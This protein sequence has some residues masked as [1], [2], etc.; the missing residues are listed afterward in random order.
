M[1]K[2]VRAWAQSHVAID[3]AT[4]RA[5][6][7]E[8]KNK[9]KRTH[10]CP[11]H[12]LCVAFLA[13]DCMICD[14][15]NNYFVVVFFCCCCIF[16]FIVVVVDLTFCAKYHI[17]HISIGTQSTVYIFLIFAVGAYC[18]QFSLEI[19]IVFIGYLC[20]LQFGIFSLLFLSVIV[21]G[22]VRFS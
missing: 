9:I 13:Y 22:A 1:I 19:F 18:S 21:S 6:L 5:L 2:N 7:I 15:T 16:F 10:V 17:V 3:A 12:T 8:E 14:K 20:A 11:V 4:V